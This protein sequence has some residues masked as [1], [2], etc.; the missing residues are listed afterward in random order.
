[1]KERNL[2]YFVSDVHLGLDVNGPAD[3][4]ERFVRFLKSIPKEET[5]TLYLLGDIWDFWYEYRDVV[6]K[7]SVRVFAALLD[8][9]D[10]G[11]K[12][13]FF[14]GNHDI[15]CY[16][17]FEDLG[18]KVM[19]QPCVVEIGGKTFCLG[20]GD[21]LGPGHFWYK[22]M[23]KCF[24][25]RFLQRLFSTLHP[26]IAFRIGRGWSKKSRVARN[27]EYLFKGE[28]EP[29]YRFATDFLQ[30]HK[31][32]CFIFGHFHTHVDME[33]PGGSR[34]MVLKDWM[35]PGT[36]PYLYWGGMSVGFG[37]SQNME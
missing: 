30:E 13:C 19:Q 24:K 36:A 26:W 7:G 11:V 18:I 25:S 22:V 32:D 29:L 21:G 14:P 33:L 9:M 23:R 10:A 16:H 35:Q 12:V 5:E 27:R 8:L 37:G 20:H 34:L 1:M 17:Y 15:W 6:P 28:E 2:T 3:R 31:V 4:E